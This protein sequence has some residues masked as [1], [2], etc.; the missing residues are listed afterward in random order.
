MS[1]YLSFY[2]LCLLLCA[3]SV[4]SQNRITINAKLNASA[5]TILVQ[6]EVVFVNTTNDTLNQLYF[7]DWANSFSS[8]QSALAKRFAENYDRKF[9]LAKN[10]DRGSTTI[11]SISDSKFSFLDYHRLDD[12]IDIVR[13]QLRNPVYPGQEYKLNIFYD[14]KLPDARFTEY[15]A[16]PNGDFN[17]RFWYLSPAVYDGKWEY[18]SN[19]NLNDLYTA[20]TNFDITF[21]LP[22][23]YEVT[24]D[25]E[26]TAL[27]SE[28]SGES[29]VKL[30]GN[31][32]NS[33][34]IFLKKISNFE[35]F[36]TEDL[37]LISNI[38]DNKVIAPS[39]A[40]I[41]DRIVRYLNDK[42]G[43][44]PF[45][46]LL[47]TEIDYKEN[48]V[49]GL[50]QLPDFIRPF[51]DGFQYELKIL[52]TSISN[53][54]DNTLYVNPRTDRWVTDGIKIYLMM[55]YMDRYYPNL[56][57][58]G[59]LEKSWLAS[60]FDASQLE[61]NDQYN[62]LYI[63]MARL[64][65]DQALAKPYDS[66][67]KFNKNIANKYKAGSGFHYLSKYL[68]SDLVDRSIADFYSSNKLKLTSSEDFRNLIENRSGKDLDWFFGDYVSTRKKI[69]Y[70]IQNAHRKG[71]SLVVTLKNKRNSQMPISLYG[72]KGDS[73]VSQQWVDGFKNLKKVTIAADSADRVALNVKGIVPEYNRRNNYRKVNPF[74]GFN[75][76][77]QFKLFQ[78]IENPAKNQVFFMPV[79]EY[80]LY[81]GLT[82][83]AKMYNKTLL[84]K[85][86][87]YKI[88]PQY[89]LKS[90]AIIG[91]LGFTYTQ[92]IE[93]GNLY[94]IRYGFSGNTFSY[95]P[96]AFYTKYT[97]FITFGFRTDDLR[98][99]KSQ[100]LT[101]RNVNVNRDKSNVIT[102]DDPDYNVFNIRYSNN[103]PGVINA[104]N[105]ET[106]FQLAKKFSKLSFTA[107]YRKVFLNNRQ[108]DL[109]IF[110]GTFLYND[111]R[112]DGDYFSFALDRPTDYMFD[113]NYYGRSESSGLFSQ[114]L[115][116]AEGGFKSILDTPF[117]NQWMFT[118]NT[119]TTLWHFIHGY[120]D[121]GLLHN[122]GLNTKFAYDSG[123]RAVLV[124]D[125]FEL[126]FP[127]YS[128]NG[129]EIAQPHYDQKIR[130]IVTLSFRT[131]FNLFTRKW[132]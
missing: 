65:L 94:A 24:T 54:V 118:A 31:S 4:W 15:G 8:K 47:I 61:F 83:G 52:K 125:Y 17:L 48:P 107:K 9:H 112:N 119:S 111:T 85:P 72:L 46:K 99:D 26:K 30:T 2:V 84:S 57:A 106:D 77:V 110:A 101:L 109:R 129:W 10:E 55:E 12:A 92:N 104:F 49:Y 68:N 28:K 23:G 97:P 67:I 121:I 43:P 27:Q 114:Q 69:D 76:P 103:N 50:N 34:R 123:I 127:V 117:A 130:F 102:N 35:T 14:L 3:N 29:A 100:Y 62:L 58:F 116:L 41:A 37:S 63:H 115:I 93:E 86:F 56:K 6:E 105:W 44:Y 74:I 5:K 80:N 66:L 45:D 88:E 81:D 73:I 89:G 132:Y 122:Q 51:P 126:F 11:K 1:K 95:A 96:D 91:G 42:L 108:F 53:Y 22:Q 32:R 128:S 79:F 124:E 19:K 40:I 70:K 39:R 90:K 7:N 120:G 131:L 87:S 20:P 33:A 16:L 78:D 21:N 38:Y 60:K 13:V 75:K 59:S 36:K 98:S 64:N 71:D 18:Y 113:Y 25:L 82:I